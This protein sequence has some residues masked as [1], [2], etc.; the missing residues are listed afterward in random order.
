L[1]SYSPE[2]N[3]LEGVWKALKKK[4]ANQIFEK[5]EELEEA[6]CE[7]LKEFWEQPEVLISMTAYRW[8]REALET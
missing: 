7:A 2:L 5:I 4:L 6:V 3:P 1:P 8:W